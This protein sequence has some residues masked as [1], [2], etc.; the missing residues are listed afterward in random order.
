[1]MTCIF[2]LDGSPWPFIIS[3][4]PIFPSTHEDPVPLPIGTASRAPARRVPLTMTLNYGIFH[5]KCSDALCYTESFRLHPSCTSSDLTWNQHISADPICTPRHHESLT[6]CV[7][8]FRLPR[9]SVQRQHVCC[10]GHAAVN[11]SQLTPNGAYKPSRF[12]GG[13]NSGIFQDT[14]ILSLPA[15]SEHPSHG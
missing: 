13:S 5:Q 14:R 1:M 8:H 6:G 3:K 10:P 2:A 15:N 12:E 7:S 4:E 9:G 11:I